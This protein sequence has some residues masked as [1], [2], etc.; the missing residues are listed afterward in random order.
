MSRFKVQVSFSSN[1]ASIFSVIKHNSSILFFCSN[2]IYFGQK[3]P[4]KVQIFEIFKCSG[5]N[6]PNS[7]R[8]FLEA[9][10]SF[11]SNFISILSSIKHN[12]SVLFKLK[13]YIFGQ[14]ELIKCKFLR[15]PKVWV[16]ISHNSSILL[17]NLRHSSF[18]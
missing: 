7:S 3:Q 15:L 1:V 9:Q 16:K 5:E 2:I 12:S 17:Q 18:S 11:P 6:L 13:H 10:A 14:K 8:Q 4:I